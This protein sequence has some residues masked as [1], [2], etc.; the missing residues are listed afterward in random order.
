VKE[1]ETAAGFLLIAAVLIPCVVA[2]LIAQ[3][4]REALRW[5]AWQDL[6]ARTMEEA[7]VGKPK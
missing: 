2:T 1:L 5:R 4:E 7:Q 3:A 6:M